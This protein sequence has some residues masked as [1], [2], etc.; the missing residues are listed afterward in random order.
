MIMLNLWVEDILNW[1]LI[2]SK[3]F[4]FCN[5]FTV[6]NTRSSILSVVLLICL[7]PIGNFRF[8]DI[9]Q[10]VYRQVNNILIIHNSS[11]DNKNDVHFTDVLNFPIY[12]WKNL[13]SVVYLNAVRLTVFKYFWFKN[14]DTSIF[15][16]SSKVYCE[17]NY[18]Q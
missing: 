12:V 15:R 3:R 18:S 16:E 13:S 8:V 4:G 5:D 9:E 17:I 11:S 1:T 10:I 6:L 2:F 7:I 14:N